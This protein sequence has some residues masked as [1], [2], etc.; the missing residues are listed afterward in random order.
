MCVLVEAGGGRGGHT[1]T[2]DTGGRWN[3]TGHAVGD[4]AL[5]RC[6][7]PSDRRPPCAC[8][9]PRCSGPHGVRR[10]LQPTVTRCAPP[11]T[12]HRLGPAQCARGSDSAG[13]DSGR[14]TQKDSYAARM[15]AA[16]C[17]TGTE[18]WRAAARTTQDSPPL[19]PPSLC[20]WRRPNAAPAGRPSRCA[21]MATSTGDPGS[22]ARTPL[23]DGATATPQVGAPRDTNWGGAGAVDGSWGRT[24]RPPP[25]RRPTPR[26]FS[27]RFSGPP[28]LV[29][30]GGLAAVAGE[31]L[32]HGCTSR[33]CVSVSWRGSLSTRCVGVW[34]TLVDDHALQ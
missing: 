22:G 16:A 31:P 32:W 8:T 14:Q 17:R 12:R 25:P 20:K 5:R 6:S 10:S 3:T 24:Q 33:R 23:A 4:A 13:N 7:P 30:V 21:P 9:P 19:P 2:T 18:K 15:Q 28:F 11:A 1:T 27:R 26:E 34:S 29:L